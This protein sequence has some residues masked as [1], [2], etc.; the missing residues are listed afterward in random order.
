MKK[1]IYFTTLF[2][3]ASTFNCLISCN[4]K[5]DDAPSPSN[6]NNNNEI[7]SVPA[8]FTQK[9][10]IEQFTGAWNGGC[11]DG[12]YRMDQLVSTGNSKV[13]GVN[14]H[15]GD[16][17]E[18]TQF[19]SFIS[20]FNNNNLPQF[21]SAMVNRIPSL[22]NVILTKTQWASN[23]NLDLAKIASCG[24][25]IKS[26]I[27][28]TTATVEVHAGF[29]S[30]IPGTYNLTVYLVESK[31]TGTGSTY[32]QVN[33]NTSNDP[34][35]PYYNKPTPITGFEHNNVIRKVAS[36]DLGDV[37]DPSKVV[38]GGEFVKTYAIDI[39]G[40]TAGNLK[41]VALINKPGTS[42]TTHEIMNIQSGE[43][44]S[45]KNWD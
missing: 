27:S 40:K 35:S 26:T 28:G 41:I 8:S 36:A 15:M 11:P 6:P 37:I 31:V 16:A 32:D 30:A 43:L 18:T 19:N 45:V 44:N 5:S 12:I 22:G 2:L 29:K 14:I 21:P 4:K 33:S 25:A 3:V 13:I 9:V 39:T 42:P 24:L 1:I 17:M 7:S 38:A 20:I 34:N 23:A 10:L